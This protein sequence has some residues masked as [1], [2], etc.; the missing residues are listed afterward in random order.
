[1]RSSEHN[2]PAVVSVK[3]GRINMPALP[4][5]ARVLRDSR[6]AVDTLRKEWTAKGRRKNGS[7]L[8]AQEQA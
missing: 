1:M 5:A 2:V 4:F 7:G 3:E 8:P 6:A